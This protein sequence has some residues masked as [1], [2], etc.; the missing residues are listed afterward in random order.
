MAVLKLSQL[1]FDSCLTFSGTENEFMGKIFEN[2]FDRPWRG[3]PMSV[4]DQGRLSSTHRVKIHL[5]E[6]SNRYFKNPE[7]KIRNFSQTKTWK[8]SKQQIE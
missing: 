5:S 3:A 1:A 7:L 2:S 6:S 4:G 8:R